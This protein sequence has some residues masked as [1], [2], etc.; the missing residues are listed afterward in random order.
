MAT[1]HR[2]LV[3]GG[4]FSLLRHQ[5]PRL[6][7]DYQRKTRSK[8]G[9]DFVSNLIAGMMATILSSPLNYVRNIHYSTSPSDI[10]QSTMVVLKDLWKESQKEGSAY[11]SFRF[12]QQRLRIG[13]GTARV[14]CGMAVGSKL[15]ELC[16]LS[17]S[18]SSSTS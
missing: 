17:N 1:V 13:W 2:D 10:P 14:G 11:R 15:Y 5:L 8:K 16:A 12:L 18:N 9:T 4:V 3:F 7:P 6:S